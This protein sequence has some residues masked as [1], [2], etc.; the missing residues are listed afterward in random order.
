MLYTSRPRDFL[1]RIYV[2]GCFACLNGSD[3]FL[4]LKRAPRKRFGDLWGVPGEEAVHGESLRYAMW[5][6]FKEETG[7]AL[8]AKEFAFIA[9]L[10]VRQE[11]E[12]CA[13]YDFHY[14]VFSFLL[15]AKTRVEINSEEHRE[16]RWLTLSAALTLPF[17]PDMPSVV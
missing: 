16:Y 4:F 3:K 15:G 5:R 2:V 17:V 11:R 1:P 9:D 13:R 10:F 7:I 14:C 8:D 6:E 12:D